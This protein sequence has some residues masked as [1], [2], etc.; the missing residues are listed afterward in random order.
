MW[1]IWKKKEEKTYDKTQWE[2]VLKV[3][4][5]T[6]E[7]VAGFRNLQTGRFREDMLIRS[8][9]DLA[10]FRESYGITGELEHIY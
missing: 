5:C 10:E 7:T 8:D 9:A 2:P 4:I 6:G 1:N 3:S